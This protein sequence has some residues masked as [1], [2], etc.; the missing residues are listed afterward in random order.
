M[1][2]MTTELI[3]IGNGFCKSMNDE[4]SKDYLLSINKL[5]NVKSDIFPGPQ[6]ISI[7]RKHMKYLKTN[8]Y[9]ILDKSDGVRYALTCLKHNERNICAL[10]DR[11]LNVKLIRLNT[12]KPC[13]D[14][15]ILDCELVKENNNYILLVFDC[16]VMCGTDVHEY[17]F[18]KRMEFAQTFTDYYKFSDNDP[19][20]VRRKDYE[21]YPKNVRKFV[22]NVNNLEYLTDGYIFMPQNQPVM[23]GTSNLIYKWKNYKNNTV[24]FGINKNKDLFLQKS[25]ELVKTRNSF[26]IEAEKKSELDSELEKQEYLIIECEN[27]TDEKTWKYIQIRKDKTIPNAVHVFRRTLNNIRENITLTEFF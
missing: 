24:D 6:P 21:S 18:T 5:W 22:N 1:N 2:Y 20:I 8:E 7:E 25:G 10:I 14:G 16:V 27:A 12:P 17:N 23:L 4:E 11:S 26:V 9:V 3:R 13:Y 15:M 19:F